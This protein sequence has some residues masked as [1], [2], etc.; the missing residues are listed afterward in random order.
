MSCVAMALSALEVKIDG[1]ESTPGS[2]NAFLVKYTHTLSTLS[3]LRT[4]NEHIIITHDAQG[5]C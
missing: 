5:T 1:D 4:H 3:T 2:L